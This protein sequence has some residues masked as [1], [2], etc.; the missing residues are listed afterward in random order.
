MG[1]L[2][3]EGYDFE[4]Q[5]GYG[6]TPLLDHL[7][8]NGEKNLAIVR[9]LLQSD[10]NVHATDHHGYNAIQCAMSPYSFGGSAER[11]ETKLSLLIEAGV[12]IHHRDDYGNT[13]SDD[14]Q[15]AY[16]CW[17]EWCLVLERHGM[18]IIEVLKAEDNMSLLEESDPEESDPEESKAGESDPEE[19]K[20]GESNAE[21]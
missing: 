19:S 8:R 3:A 9:L 2:R 1:F 13:P 15:Y 10:V 18:D 7:S 16:G 17:N 11:L 4:Q 21:E 12:D 14:V 20:A 5:D 6:R